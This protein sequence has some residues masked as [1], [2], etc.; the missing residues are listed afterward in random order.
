MNKSD[1]IRNISYTRS[2]RSMEIIRKGPFAK[3]ADEKAKEKFE[4]GEITMFS[5]PMG[6]DIYISLF[7]GES[8]FLISQM[9]GHG[10]SVMFMKMEV[11][12]KPEPIYTAY[13]LGEDKKPKG[14][15]RSELHAALELCLPKE[16]V[17]MLIDASYIER[18]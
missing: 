17:R 5:R 8:A 6:S 18:K 12:S 7:D 1:I 16:I 10:L 11:D 9:G 13:S 2:E 4:D 3:Q 14:Q 15:M